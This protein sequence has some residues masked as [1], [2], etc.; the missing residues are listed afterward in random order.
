MP[1]AGT[2]GSASLCAALVLRKQRI[3]GR[4]YGGGH[5]TSSLV[6]VVVSPAQCGNRRAADHRGRCD[7]RAGSIQI[8][9]QPPLYTYSTCH[10]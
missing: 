1:A 2:A 5:K 3:L 10:L 4:I 6:S 8:H 9:I 7:N